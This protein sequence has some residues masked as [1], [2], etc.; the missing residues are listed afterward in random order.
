MSSVVLIP[1]VIYPLLTPI[2]TALPGKIEVFYL[3]K[4]FPLIT[5]IIEK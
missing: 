2:K 3:D 1:S 5:W 4:K